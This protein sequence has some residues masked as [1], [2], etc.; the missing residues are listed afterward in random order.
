MARRVVPKIRAGQ[1]LSVGAKAKLEDGAAGRRG[2]G[3]WEDAAPWQRNYGR[4]NSGGL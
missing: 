2:A 3:Q 4:V 1:P